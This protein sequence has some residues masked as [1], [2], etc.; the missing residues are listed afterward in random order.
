LV[1]RCPK[2]ITPFL[3]TII[4]LCLEYIKYDP[5]YAESEDMETEEADEEEEE[6]EEAEEEEEDYSDDDDMSWKVRRSAVKCLSVVILTRPELLQQ[7]Y[8]KVSQLTSLLT[9]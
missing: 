1:H 2:E 8:D 9:L 5:N 4:S 6:E 3:D 7:I